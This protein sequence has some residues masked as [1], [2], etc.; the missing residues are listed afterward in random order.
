[1]GSESSPSEFRSCPCSCLLA[2]CPPGVL[3]TSFQHSMRLVTHRTGCRHLSHLARCAG[4]DRSRVR[5]RPCNS[6]FMPSRIQKAR[7]IIPA[8]RCG[9]AT[10]RF[11][12]RQPSTVGNR[13]GFDPGGVPR[14]CIFSSTGHACFF[15][16]DTGPPRRRI[17]WSRRFVT[18]P[19]APLDL[20]LLPIR[21]RAWWKPRFRRGHLS[22]DDALTC[23]SVSGS[24]PNS[25]SL[26]TF[27]HFSAG[28]SMP[29]T[30]YGHRSSRRTARG[31]KGARAGMTFAL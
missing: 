8:M 29:L 20:A 3:S 17:G 27:H 5:A 30:S 21:I 9:S 24:L 7:A 15:A 31:C 28:P 22:S 4:A 11:M 2:S 10:S 23:S 14:T 25:L 13:Y 19:P 26:G 12:E 6:G 18:T 16:G 1:M